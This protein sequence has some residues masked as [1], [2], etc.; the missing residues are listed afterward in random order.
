MI[1]LSSHHVKQISMNVTGN[2]T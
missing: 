1:S 2:I